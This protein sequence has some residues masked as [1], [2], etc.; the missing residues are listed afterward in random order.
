[1]R[2]LDQ[3]QKVHE[4]WGQYRKRRAVVK[5]LHQR[6]LELLQ[7]LFFFCETLL[8]LGR[9]WFQK[10]RVVNFR[11]VPFFVAQNFIEQL[12]AVHAKNE[13]KQK[14]KERKA[15]KLAEKKAA[16]AIGHRAKR[17]DIRK[18]LLEKKRKEDEE[19][20]K[21]LLEA[22]QMLHALISKDAARK[23]EKE[24]LARAKEKLKA[25][26]HQ[27]IAEADE[28]VAMTTLAQEI[29]F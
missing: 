6:E 1:M 5:E 10:I 15:K 11:L 14:K 26:E 12:E 23:Q 17:K 21:H 27:K 20:A 19:R 28:E 4:L 25:A 7:V 8:E 3:S 18:Y 2:G 9:F 13:L 22:E 24:R 29:D 16:S